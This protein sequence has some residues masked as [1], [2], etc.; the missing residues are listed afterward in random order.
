MGFIMG[1]FLC[2]LA[3]I[4]VDTLKYQ[5]FM[6]FLPKTGY[7]GLKLFGVKI[8]IANYDLKLSLCRCQIKFQ[9]TPKPRFSK[10][11]DLVNKLQLPFS[12]FTMKASSI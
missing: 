1:E 8:H 3:Y 9:S 4:I 7:I 11:H 5:I 12:Y 10:Y 6:T 2:L